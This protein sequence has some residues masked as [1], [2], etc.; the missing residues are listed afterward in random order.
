M[1]WRIVGGLRLLTHTE[2]NEK[3]KGKERRSKEVSFKDG[4][5]IKRMK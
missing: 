1:G 4:I 3:K 2:G 5:I